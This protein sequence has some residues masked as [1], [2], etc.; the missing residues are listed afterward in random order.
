MRKVLRR[1]GWGTRDP[2]GMGL[3]PLA[4]PTHT[5]KEVTKDVKDPQLYVDIIDEGTDRE[6]RVRR[7]HAGSAPSSLAPYGL[8][9]SINTHKIYEVLKPLDN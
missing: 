9:P 6:E 7:G 8:A 4:V 5:D 2:E 1:Y 3:R